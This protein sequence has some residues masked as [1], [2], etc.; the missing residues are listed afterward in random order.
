[1]IVTDADPTEL[2]AARPLIS[3]G[4][5]RCDIERTTEDRHSSLSGVVCAL[6]AGLAVLFSLPFAKMGFIDD[7]SYVR[8]AYN[9]AQTGHFVY[10]GW[11]TAM[12][13]WQI[14]WAAPFLKLFGYS[15]TVARLSMLP[16]AMGCGWLLHA[17]LRHSGISNRNAVFG[18]LA[19]C[20][21]PLFI[22][23]AASYMSDVG[24]LFVILL[25]MYLCQR[26]LEAKS[27]RHAVLWLCGAGLTNIV[28][29]T[30]RQ[31]IWLGILVLIPSAA[32][33]MRKRRGVITAAIVLWLIGVAFI[34][35][36]VHWF[37]SHP[38][39]V[40]EKIFSPSLDYP[41]AS[42]FDLFRKRVKPS[43]VSFKVQVLSIVLVKTLFCLELILLPLLVAWL[44]TIR[45]LGRRAWVTLGSLAALLG[46]AAWL[47]DKSDQLED[48][49]MPWIFHVLGTEGISKSTWDMLGNRPVSIPPSL[50]IAISLLVVMSG[51]V[52]IT[53]LS[54]SKRPNPEKSTSETSRWQTLF[55]LYLPYCAVYVLLLI[56]R[57]FRLFL[58]DRYLLYIA[59]IAI[60]YLLKLH[61]ERV[62][63]SLPLISYLTLGVFAIYG[64]FATHDLFALNRARVVA[65]Q[66]I[67]STGV[68]E[69]AV[70]A[71]FEYDGW[72]EIDQ[73]HYVNESRIAF[74]ADA[75]RLNLQ[76]RFRPSDCRLGFDPYTPALHPRFIVVLSP[77][78]CLEQS[79]FPPVLYHA[80]LPP[81]TRSIY[82]QR[83]PD[84]MQDLIPSTDGPN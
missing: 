22:P 6:I 41:G 76:D 18:S 21:S 55:I 80:W 7:W 50:R 72:S 69:N 79:N 1:M 25:C 30:E 39:S 71:G 58:F 16:F 77:M 8:T 62:R 17:I 27:D 2:A 32:W 70:Q 9:F 48:W 66:A 5:R 38:Y 82:I 67:R 44:M 13:G 10:N 31:I 26:A 3:A 65:V 36:G 64:I 49:L 57:S 56:P 61:Q 78:W 53:W 74:P 14:P 45:T 4:N 15:F 51:A 59:P 47:L 40:P 84:M 12:L 24:G 28:G 29:G 52:F 75:Y 73:A 34:L 33:L 11:A 60:L 19:V 81:F 43:Y 42:T 37:Y 35:L 23:L 20:T 68:K 54:V 46:A 63:K 83:V